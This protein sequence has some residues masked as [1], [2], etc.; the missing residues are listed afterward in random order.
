M[1]FGI[2]L[3][4]KDPC[5]VAFNFGKMKAASE[6]V[7]E[8]GPLASNVGHINHINQTPPTRLTSSGCQVVFTPVGERCLRAA[9][10]AAA[11]KVQL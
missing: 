10:A 5:G 11:P 2:C 4:T 1:H 8:L 7:F 9:K 3:A 6:G